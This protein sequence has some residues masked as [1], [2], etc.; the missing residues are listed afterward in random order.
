MTRWDRSSYTRSRQENRTDR[1]KSKEENLDPSSASNLQSGTDPPGAGTPAAD[2]VERRYPVEFTATAGEYFRIWIVNLGLTILTLG[3]YSAWAKVRKRRYFYGHTRIDGDSFEYRGNPI[4]ILKGRLIAV[5]AVAMFYGTGHFAPGLQWIIVVAAVFAVPWLI[6]RSLA[7]KAYNSAYRN[8]RL[9]FRGTYLE[10]LKIIVGYALLMIVT[11]GL[12]Y[13][14]LKARLVKFAA[15]QHLYGATQFEIADLRQQFRRIFGNGVVGIGL[16]T[17]IVVSALNAGGATV[18]GWRPDSPVLSVSSMLVSYGGLLIIFA[19]SR[20]RYGNAAW[21]NI[22]I[23][24]VRFECALR[25][26]DLLWLYMVNILAIIVTLG[27]ATPWAAVRTMRYRAEKMILV[28]AGAL[29]GFVGA[30]STQVSAAGEEVGEM[31]DIDIA[32]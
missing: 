27:L 30:E 2:T 14:Y 13:P 22:T 23:G 4:A 24:P 28:S 1:N 25:V 19:Y 29:D 18:F 16:L 3:I 21:N 26:R 6:V 7:F 17:G 31:F 9:H 12:A 10:C 15:S 8:I 20:A 5:G 11:L 32:V